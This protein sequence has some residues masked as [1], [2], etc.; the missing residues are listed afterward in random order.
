MSLLPHPLAR[1]VDRLARRAHDFHRFAHHPLCSPYSGEVL[2]LGR[3]T[4]VCLGCALAALGAALG[5]GLGLL[6]PALPGPVLLCGG[7]ALLL[8]VP[9]ALRRP[10]PR[11]RLAPPLRKLVTRF[12]PTL[13]AGAIVFQSLGAPSPGRLAAGGEAAAAVGLGAFVYRRRGPDRSP[14][15]GCPMGPP[16]MEC[17][18]F[19][20]VARRERAFSRLAGRW[21]AAEVPGRR[22]ST[23]W[24]RP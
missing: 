24:P 12:L 2:R 18:G 6:L 11:P 10:S 15:V 4:R 22:A 1:R 20:P 14:C 21:I 16:R 8:L 9:L 3:R 5:S 23:S 13:V 19:F 17:P 7:L